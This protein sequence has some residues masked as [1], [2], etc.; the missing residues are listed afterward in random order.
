MPVASR[1]RRTRVATMRACHFALVALVLAVPGACGK[2]KPEAPAPPPPPQLS[3]HD[4]TPADTAA[5][6]RMVRAALSSEAEKG[7]AIGHSIDP[8]SLTPTELR[9][10]RSPK[11]SSAVVYQDSIVLMEN[12][13]KALRSM[14]SD[15][16]TWHFDANAPHVSEIQ[17]GKVIFATERCV[18]TVLG[19][20][21]TGDDVAVVLGPVQLTDVIK[22]G[23][24]AFN[25]P[26]DLN[27]LIAVTAPGYPWLASQDTLA[28]HA[29]AR[30]HISSITY[31]LVSSDGTWR[32][33]RTVTSGA[34]GKLVLTK[35]NHPSR[36]HSRGGR[37]GDSFVVPKTGWIR[38]QVPQ[39]PS[40]MPQGLPGVPGIPN[41]NGQLPA[42]APS[43]GPPPT[44]DISGGLVATPC[45]TDCGGL[46]IKLSYD[47]GGVLVIAYAV[48]KVKDVHL[49]FNLDVSGGKIQTA[50]LELSGAAGFA[51]HFETGTTKDFNGNI[52]QT[53][54]APID[55][56]IPVGGFGMPISVHFLQS[57]SLNTGFSAKTSKLTADGDYFASG[58]ILVGYVRGSWGGAPPLLG[59][60]QNL[61][62]NVGGISMG[63]NSLAF[64][65]RQEVLVG[66]GALGF[67]AGP[68][69]ALTTGTTA[70]KQSSATPI[71]CH[72]ATFTMDLTAG[73]GYTLPKP[74]VSVFNFFLRA[75]HVK[76]LAPNGSIAEMPPQRVVEMLSQSPHGCAG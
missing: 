54:L 71:D 6:A 61:A 36:R 50:A 1:E 9:F 37:V 17:A 75:L 68:Y 70:L 32:P 60:K 35:W 38:V 46:G 16:L 39:I 7:A 48:F 13:D 73:A 49:H 14:S 44:V 52:H 10:G 67:S 76:E 3:A 40:G 29:S 72:Q 41:P 22:Q 18:G 15:G 21:R 57:L 65:I 28:H 43:I 59:T 11:Q 34:D 4:T 74:L 55:L 31:A 5:G 58:S 42:P 47:Q 26:L 12:G 27:S 62:D 20:T 24:F 63:I 53:G 19:V 2:D 56:S 51:V 64:G 45:L 25:Q 69:L 30:G 66:I 23:H 8:H 33:T